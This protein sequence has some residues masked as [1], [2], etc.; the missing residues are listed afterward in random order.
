M[1]ISTTLG[2]NPL[3]GALI[4]A[5]FALAGCGGGS[6]DD[7]EKS[8]TNPAPA[9]S[10]S[11]G[12]APSANA[13]RNA[14]IMSLSKAYAASYQLPEGDERDLAFAAAAGELP[15]ECRLIDGET[16]KK[17][18]DAAAEVAIPPG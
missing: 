4:A 7:A 5:V 13:C 1:R 2:S 15:S 18:R 11:T 12:A 3:A 6:D 9:P 17:L 8:G 16:L 10:S 14:M